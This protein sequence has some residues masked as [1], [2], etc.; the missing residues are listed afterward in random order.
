M[1]YYGPITPEEDA[2]FTRA[3]L[4]LFTLDAEIHGKEMENPR[5]IRITQDMQEKQCDSA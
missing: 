2:L 1:D 4:W 5:I 3:L